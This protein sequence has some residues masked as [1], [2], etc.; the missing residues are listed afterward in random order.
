MTIKTIFAVW[1]G[2]DE[3]NQAIDVAIDLVRETEGHL[4]VLCLGMDR[5]STGFYYAG[6]APDLL[7]ESQKAARETATAR[8]AEAKERLSREEI[9]WAVQ[10]AVAQIGGINDVVC[11]MGRF[12]DLI[13]LPRPYGRAAEEENTAIVEAA[14][15]QSGTPLMILPPDCPAVSRKRITLPWN[16]SPEALNAAKS[17]L[18]WL[19]DA[20]QVYVTMVAPAR[21]DADRSDPGTSLSVFLDRHGANV[22]VAVLPQTQSRVSDVIMTHADDVASDL[23]VMGGYS[24]SRFREALLGGTT[25]EMLTSCTVPVVMAH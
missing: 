12:A 9:S 21:H 1:D 15:M 25:R 14:L 24:K 2:T 23:I 17:M 22:Q 4:D 16:E 20:E 19:V 6:A 7:F 18:G 13:V 10:P 11:Q 3:G 5:L 8:E